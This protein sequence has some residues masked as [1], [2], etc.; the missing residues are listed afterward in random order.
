MFSK[1]AQWYDLVYS[2]KDY[3]EEVHNIRNLIRAKRPEATTILDVACGTGEHARFLANDFSV[4]GIDLQPEFVAAAREKVGAGYFATADMRSFDLARQYD[5]VQC[6]FSSIGYLTSP[7][8]VVAALRSFK[9]HLNKDGIVIVEPWF[10]PD[11]Y[12]AGTLHMAPPVDTPE[13]K[14]VRM[15]VSSREGNLSRLHFHY[16]VGRPDGVEHIEEE[17][18]L[19]LYSVGEMVSFFERAGLSVHYDPEGI[20]GRGLYVGQEAE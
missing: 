14:I 6:L 3:A 15:N 11:S 16:L 17:H 7:S 8:D 19:A 13:L 9:K 1:T 12:H 2:F 20:F 10:T 18:V 5:V 4:D